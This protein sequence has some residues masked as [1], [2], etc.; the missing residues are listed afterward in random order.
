M[1][2][3]TIIAVD[4]RKDA[5]VLAGDVGADHA[6][7]AGES[8]AQEITELTRG[9]GAELVIDVVGA[10]A[11]LELAAA[12][13][14]PLGHLT[15]VGLGGG[16]LPISFFGIAYEV[17]VATT[18]WGT[19]PEMVEVIELARAGKVHVKSQRFPLDE[20]P[21]VYASLQAGEIDGRAVIVPS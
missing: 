20:A 1:S 7:M 17:S 16:T 19:L 3:A 12:V 14:R 13:T 4:Q 21:Q 18:Y 10:D 2:P 15:I 6:V 5:L 11:T 8:A 9:R